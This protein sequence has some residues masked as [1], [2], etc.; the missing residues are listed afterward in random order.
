MRREDAVTSARV[1]PAALCAVGMA[2]ALGTSIALAHGD[3]VT[4]EEG[5]ISPAELVVPAGA[6]VHFRNAD[7][8]GRTIVGEG[9]S[10]E[11]PTLA[12]GEDW[13]QH[14]PFPGAFSFELKE[15]PGA[16][17]VVTVVRD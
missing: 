9:G 6:V 8:A 1:W 5:G 12:P 2:I 11:S 17:G 3:T 13:H 10:F 15:R 14:F 7:T 4:I 16:K